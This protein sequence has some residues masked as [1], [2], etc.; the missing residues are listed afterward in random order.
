[1]SQVHRVAV[2]QIMSAHAVTVSM[3]DSLR[4]VKELFDKHR[5][6]HLLVVEGRKLVGVISDRDLLKNVSPFVGRELTERAQDAATLNKRV[7]QIMSRKPVTVSAEATMSDVARTMLD[8]QVSC[9]PVVDREG[10]PVG[11]ITWRDLLRQL[12]KETNEM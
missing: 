10:H 5:F 2:R 4:T 1:M 8:N 9:L 6:H 12:I 7:H 11:I 3:D